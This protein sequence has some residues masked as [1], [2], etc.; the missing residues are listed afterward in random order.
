LEV[1]ET[2]QAVPGSDA[3]RRTTKVLLNLTAGF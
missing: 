1:A 2:L 3:G